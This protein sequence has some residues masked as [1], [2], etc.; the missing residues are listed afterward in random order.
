MPRWTQKTIAKQIIDNVGDYVLALK[1]NQ[2]TLN[3]DIRL[4]LETELKKSSSTIMK[5]PIKGMD[6]SILAYV[7]LVAR[8]T[9]LLKKNNGLD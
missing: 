4:F 2:G 1:D 3:D 7:M 5:K 9:G 6:V 8:L